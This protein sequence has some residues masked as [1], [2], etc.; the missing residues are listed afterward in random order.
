MA[1]FDKDEVS[2]LELKRLIDQIKNN[3]IEVL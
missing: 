3:K 2:E 1:R